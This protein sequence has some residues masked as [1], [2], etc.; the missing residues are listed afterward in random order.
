MCDFRPRCYAA[1]GLH[2]CARRS[3]ARLDFLGPKRRRG[4][5]RR[6][7]SG[8]GSDSGEVAGAT[9]S[10]EEEPGPEEEDE[11]EEDDEEGWAAA[12]EWVCARSLA[13]ARFSN[14]K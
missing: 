2:P 3:A 9:G 8:H 1:P 4:V 10:A 11:E 12:D 14:T 6:R 5:R 7:A 13:I